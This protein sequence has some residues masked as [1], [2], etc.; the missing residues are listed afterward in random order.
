MHPTRTKIGLDKTSLLQ[1]FGDYA[2][3]VPQD[4]KIKCI[5]CHRKITLV[6]R[7]RWFCKTR[8]VEVYVY[9]ISDN[10]EHY[11]MFT[12]CKCRMVDAVL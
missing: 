5:H 6:S 1:I 3:M 10:F 11:N 2:V 9:R 12:Y 7:W 4:T 8:Y